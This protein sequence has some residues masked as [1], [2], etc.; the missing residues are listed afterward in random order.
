MNKFT[1]IE[2]FVSRLPGAIPMSKQDCN[3]NLSAKRPAL[4][5][6]AAIQPY[7]EAGTG[8]SGEVC[9]LGKTALFSLYL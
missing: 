7:R 4:R 6:A 5:T 3:E 2:G 1:M 8:K 9:F